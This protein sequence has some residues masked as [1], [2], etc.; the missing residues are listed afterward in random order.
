VADQLVEHY[1]RVL[2]ARAAGTPVVPLKPVR[3]A[4]LRRRAS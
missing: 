4:R 3:L 2:A 1:A